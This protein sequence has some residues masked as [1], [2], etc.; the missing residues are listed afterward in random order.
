MNTPA[1][2]NNGKTFGGAL[3]QFVGN[4]KGLNEIQHG[5]ADA[6]YRSYLT[7][8]PDE[9]FSV[10]VFSN[11]AEFGSRRMAHKVADIYLKDRLKVEPDKEVAK[12]ENTTQTITVDQNTLNTYIGDFELQPGFIISITESNGKLSGQATGQSV[13]SLIPVSNTEFK[14]EGVEAKIEFIP[15]GD[16][17]IESIKLHQSGQIREAPRLKPFDKAAV[18][19]SDFSGNFY[20]EELTTSYNFII[21]EGKLKARHNRLSDFNLDP[22]K[23]DVFTGDVWFFGQIEFLRDDNNLITGCKVSNGRVR[24]LYFKKLN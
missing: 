2:L 5:G 14:I 8:F 9:N 12:N 23:E 18:N 20:S 4:Y 10:I 21:V 22:V 16:E 6:G 11:S 3:G 24:N 19:L 1:H 7:R 13:I 15:N 17:N